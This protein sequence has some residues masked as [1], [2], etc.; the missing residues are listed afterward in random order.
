VTPVAAFAAFDEAGRTLAERGLVRA[1]E[2]NLSTSD[3]AR[4]TIT[5]TGCRQGTL[6]APPPGSSSDLAIHVAMYRDRG[7][8]A[9]AHAHPPGTVPDGWIEGEP[10][11][12]YAFASSIQG[13]V[14]E[15]VR[16]H[17]GTGA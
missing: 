1:S 8:G 13:A 10:H 5:R 9:I 3:G 2:G 14:G 17:G 11:G 15:L 4:L 16:T 12:V 6:D 7:P